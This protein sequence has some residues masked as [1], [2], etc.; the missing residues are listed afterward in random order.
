MAKA[1]ISLTALKNE[2]SDELGVAFLYG[3]DLLSWIECVLNSDDEDELS[4]FLEDNYDDFTTYQREHICY[5]IVLFT[6]ECMGIAKDCRCTYGLSLRANKL[7]FW[8]VNDRR[9]LELDRLKAANK[10]L[11][12]ENHTLTLLLEEYEQ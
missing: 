3:N 4:Y 8:K 11:L 6:E 5:R 12:A 9:D 1:V 10:E 7:S 2:L